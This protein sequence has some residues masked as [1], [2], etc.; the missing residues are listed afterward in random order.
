MLHTKLR[1][2]DGV[3]D[4]VRLANGYPTDRYCHCINPESVAEQLERFPIGQFVAVTYEDGAEKVIGMGTTMITSR[5][6]DHEPLPWYDV[7]GSFGLRNHDPE[8]DWLYGVE[9]AVHPDYQRNGVASALYKARLA[10]ID[11]LHLKGWYAGGMLMGYDD[12]RDTLTPRQY[13]ELVIAGE[14]TDPTVTMQLHRGLEPR[15][16]IEG[17]Y[18]EWKAGH[19]AVL[20]VHEPQQVPSVHKKNARGGRTAA[21]AT[22]AQA[23]FAA[24]RSP[25]APTTARFSGA[26]TGTTN[27]RSKR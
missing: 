10:L 13:A 18:P 1:H 27:T 21:R 14:L 11:E 2:A 24:S 17:Y 9:I 16:I 26:T 6:P 19:A 7:I 20:L 22:S 4:V 25:S 12:H 8:G 15:A 3:Y 5:S 23:P